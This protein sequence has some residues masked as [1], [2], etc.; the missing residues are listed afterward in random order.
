MAQKPP[1]G[2]ARRLIMVPFLL[3]RW[4]STGPMPMENSKTF[5]PHS[6]AAMKCPHSCTPIRT[7]NITMARRIYRNVLICRP[8]D[9]ISC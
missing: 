3:S 9:S 6:R 5:T 8:F 1:I 2:R 4:K 7:P